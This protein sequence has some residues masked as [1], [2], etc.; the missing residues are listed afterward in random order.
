MI[1]CIT[2]APGSG[3]STVANLLASHGAYLVDMDRLGRQ[4]TLLSREKIE[5][6]LGKGF[7]DE[8][9][10]LIPGKLG[11]FLFVEHPEMI[12]RFNRIVHPILK[13]LVSEEIEKHKAAD[14][15]VDGALVFELSVSK[16]CDLIIVVNSPTDE[17]VKRFVRR[18][19]YPKSAFWNILKHQMPIEEKLKMADIVIDNSRGLEQLQS[20]IDGLRRKIWG[21]KGT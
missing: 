5:Q 20:Q 8:D 14:V 13:R 21:I 4:A 10:R 19:G 15:V 2:G 7:F 1:I 6:V 17:A 18:T 12:E 11:R 3:K 9:G 16:L